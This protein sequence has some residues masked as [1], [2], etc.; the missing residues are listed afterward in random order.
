MTLAISPYMSTY[1]HI[2]LTVHEYLI[3]LG[4]SNKAELKLADF[5]PLLTEPAELLPPAPRFA[6]FPATLNYSKLKRE[7]KQT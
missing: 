1:I 3:K 4:F 5:N 6:D 2:R 7:S